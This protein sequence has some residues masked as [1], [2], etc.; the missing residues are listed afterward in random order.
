MRV[1]SSWFIV[2]PLDSVSSRIDLGYVVGSEP[3]IVIYSV[4]C[5]SLCD[6]LVSGPK[7]SCIVN[8]TSFLSV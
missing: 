5:F 3:Y 7:G 2:A 1:D 4:S 6:L 8:L